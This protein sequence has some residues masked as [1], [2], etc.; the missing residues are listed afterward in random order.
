MKPIPERWCR[1]NRVRR[2]TRSSRWSSVLPPSGCVSRMPTKRWSPV[3]IL[4]WCSA[5]RGWIPGLLPT[6]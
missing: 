3:R 1:A 2:I 5:S 6:R 4:S